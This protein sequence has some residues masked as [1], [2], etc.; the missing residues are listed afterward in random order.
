MKSKIQILTFNHSDID[1]ALG[2]C[3]LDLK[4]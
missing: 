4:R 1:L 3:H 2:F